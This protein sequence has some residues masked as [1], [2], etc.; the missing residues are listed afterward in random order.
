MVKDLIS[1]I[2]PVFNT[3]RYLRRSIGSI[4][5]NNY[6]KIEVLCIDDGSTDNSLMLLRQIAEEDARVRVITQKNGGVSSA[7]NRG[8]DMANGEWICFLDSDD[9]VHIDFLQA[10][11][12]SAS[13]NNADIVIAGLKEVCTEDTVARIDE[14]S[15]LSTTCMSL[16]EATARGFFRN[17]V[18]GRI[19]KRSVVSSIRFPLNMQLGEDQI[20]NSQIA[21][22]QMNIK[23]CSVDRCL[24]FY[25]MREDSLVHSGADRAY[26]DICYWYLRHMNQFKKKNY[27]ILQAFRSI[28]MYRYRADILQRETDYQ[29]RVNQAIKECLCFLWSE[30]TISIKDKIQFSVAAIS[31]RLY[32]MSLIIKDKSILDWERLMKDRSN[33]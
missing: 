12:S 30:R 7:R 19:F 10:L 9:W 23:I 15:V 25:Y 29:E 27:V 24:Y 32:R 13:E 18:T 14:S 3:E 4:L 11:L 6:K 1:V 8:L 17:Y 28:L 33:L 2:I 16:D 22:S 31:P 21:A 26:C 5:N 20:F